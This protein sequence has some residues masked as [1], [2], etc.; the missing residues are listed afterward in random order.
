MKIIIMHQ[1]YIIEGT[2]EIVPAVRIALPDSSVIPAPTRSAELFEMEIVLPTFATAA[3]LAHPTSARFQL[4][5]LAR[6]AGV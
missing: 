1:I 6:Q 2:M 4:V 5:Q 3:S